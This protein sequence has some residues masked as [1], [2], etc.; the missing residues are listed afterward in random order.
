MMYIDCAAKV[1]FFDDMTEDKKVLTIFH[2]SP[3]RHK[4]CAHVFG[5]YQMYWLQTMYLLWDGE[6]D[7]HKPELFIAL[8]D[9]ELLFGFVE[10]NKAIETIIKYKNCFNLKEGE[11]LLEEPNNENYKLFIEKLIFLEKDEYEKI[12]KLIIENEETKNDYLLKKLYDNY[13][14]DPGILIALFMN[15]LHKKLNY[16]IITFINYQMPQILI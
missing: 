3:C 5:L 4:Y 6:D 8:S 2:R 15:H 9:F 1:E 11:K 16:H 10:M 7:N 13:G 12:I 14:L